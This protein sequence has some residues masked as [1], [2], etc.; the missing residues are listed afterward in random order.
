LSTSHAAGDETH[1][2]DLE[3]DKPTVEDH[4]SLLGYIRLAFVIGV[5]S[6]RLEV[7]VDHDMLVVS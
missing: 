5:A 7:I 2:I 6:Q 4:E 3:G 1:A